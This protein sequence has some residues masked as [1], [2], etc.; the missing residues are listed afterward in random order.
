MVPSLRSAG[1]V[2]HPSLHRR[3]KKSPS[4]VAWGYRITFTKPTISCIG[5]Y[6]YAEFV[7][8]LAGAVQEGDDGL[9]VLANVFD[10][11]DD[12]QAVTQD[13]RRMVFVK[14]TRPACEVAKLSTG[15]RIQVLGIPRVNLSEVAVMAT[16]EPAT[17]RLP[18]EMIIVAVQQEGTADCATDS[19]VKPKKRG[20]AKP[21]NSS[22]G[23]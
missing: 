13:A 1:R 18:Y 12:E 15:D 2:G 3:C 20:K 6:N 17:T 21:G 7:I 16:E 4:A 14:G 22:G 19:K 8:E 23:E 11:D 5:K 10:T 9:F